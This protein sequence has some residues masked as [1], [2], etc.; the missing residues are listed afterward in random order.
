MVEILAQEPNKFKSNVL[1]IIYIHK[2]EN[3]VNFRSDSNKLNNIYNKNQ[4]KT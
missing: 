2:N 1:E 4:Y 3:T